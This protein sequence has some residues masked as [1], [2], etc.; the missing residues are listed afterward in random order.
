MWRRRIARGIFIAGVASLISPS[1][2]SRRCF[3]SST[4]IFTPVCGN[5]DYSR[6]GLGSLESKWKPTACHFFDMDDS[7]IAISCGGAH[8]LF[9]TCGA[10]FLSCFFS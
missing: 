6:L 3:S 1:G 2:I 5:K 4:R 8:T 10:C 7:R 9:L